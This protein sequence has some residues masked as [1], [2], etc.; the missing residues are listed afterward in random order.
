M[1]AE[2]PRIFRES[3]AIFV[4]ATTEPLEALLLGGNVA[5][6]HE[7]RVT[8]FGPTA[9]VYRRPVDLVTAF[10]FSDPPLN[11]VAVAKTA[12][13][14]VSRNGALKMPATGSFEDLADG[15]YIVGLRPHHLHLSQPSA[16]AVAVRAI[17]TVS[18][19]TGSESFI[20]AGFADA[21]WVVSAQGVHN[22]EP[23]SEI[24][25]WVDPARMFVFDQAG[26][27]AAAPDL[28]AAA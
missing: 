23:G 25:I 7:G 2:L 3:G 11:S 6:L 22:L 17:V 24:E 21:K 15:D 26:G 12:Q 18:E 14:V 20:H 16:E 19:I 1:R 4:Y 28:A 27:L 5:T 9:E 13:A 8:Q 10:T